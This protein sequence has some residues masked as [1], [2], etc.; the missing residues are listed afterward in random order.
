[1][2]APPP[3]AEMSVEISISKRQPHSR[4]P[5]TC[6][7]EIRPRDCRRPTNRDSGSAND[8][9]TNFA[10]YRRTQAGSITHNHR[11]KK[12][13][14]YAKAGSGRRRR[15]LRR[16]K[17]RRDNFATAYQGLSQM[18][19][20]QSAYPCFTCVH[21]WRANISHHDRPALGHHEHF[22]L[23]SVCTCCGKQPLR[24]FVERLEPERERPVMHRD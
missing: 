23:D 12:R 9:R 8:L 14:D 16:L 18:Q 5:K 3:V 22:L 24:G 21:P 1:M 10:P 20:R 17:M 19:K 6:R 2:K 7:T 11:S 4:K 13:V 15:R